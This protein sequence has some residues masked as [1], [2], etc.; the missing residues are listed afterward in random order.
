[1]HVGSSF[2]GEQFFWFFGIHGDTAIAPIFD[3]VALATTQ[4]N[5]E[6][7]IAGITLPHIY[8]VP[9]RNFFVPA[10]SSL[11]IAILIAG[12]NEQNRIVAKSTIAP[13]I[14]NISEPLVFG[15]PIV[16]NPI[17]FIPWI[18]I[19][20]VYASTTYFVMKTVLLPYTTDLLF[21][22]RPLNFLQDF[23]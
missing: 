21:L 1:M 7:F 16:L 8:T 10:F 22:G 2:G 5:Y 12:K 23:S 20:C 19:R 15:L 18:F 14:F 11:V 6:A 3:P 17:L 4:E 13:A 9:F